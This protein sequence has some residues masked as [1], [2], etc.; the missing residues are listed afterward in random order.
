MGYHSHSFGEGDEVAVSAGAVGH[1]IGGSKR[2]GRSTRARAARAI[3]SSRS[4]LVALL[5]ALAV[6]AVG[7]AIGVPAAPALT[8]AVLA[9]AALVDLRERRLPDR[10]VLSAMTVLTV[11]AAVAT[12][13]DDPPAL[14]SI[15]AG[16][17]VMAVPLLVLHLVSPR[18]MGFG[19]V[20]ATIVLGA[21][22]G[23]LDWRLGLVAL[24]IAAAVAAGVGLARRVD[25][26]AFGPFLVAATALTLF[27]VATISTPLPIGTP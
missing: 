21:A 2:A 24:S 20:K 12:L 17:A 7:V 15:A 4:E 22:L 23:W 8:V 11:G 3:D 1:V 19:D 27:A 14:A 25:T 18:A 5:V 9:P 6:A 13:V 10:W 26:I 16:A